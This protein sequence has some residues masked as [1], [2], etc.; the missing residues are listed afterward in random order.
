LGTVGGARRHETEEPEATRTHQLAVNERQRQAAGGPEARRSSADPRMEV[1][2][3]PQLFGG[4]D[5]GLPRTRTD[6]D[7]ERQLDA[8]VSDR[9][10]LDDVDDE[11][12][13]RISFAP[14]TQDTT[15]SKRGRA[16]RGSFARAST[17]GNVTDISSAQRSIGRHGSTSPPPSIVISGA[18]APPPAAGPQ[19]SMSSSGRDGAPRRSALKSRNNP[20]TLLPGSRLS[21]GGGGGAA[22]ISTSASAQVAFGTATT[23]F[24]D[25]AADDPANAQ[26]DEAVRKANTASWNTQLRTSRLMALRLNCM[27]FPLKTFPPYDPLN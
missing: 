23:S 19:G 14:D 12:R 8:L 3:R 7:Y 9:D 10:L 20:G 1:E 17:I 18:A 11:P 16:K 6:E 4:S 24:F 25:V 2:N 27:E 13:P 26:E 22:A 15:T 21:P 5:S